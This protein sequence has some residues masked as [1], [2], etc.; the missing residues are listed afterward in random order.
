[1]TNPVVDLADAR[2]KKLIKNRIKAGLAGKRIAFVVW[3]NDPRRESAPARSNPLDA[4]F[5][6]NE[7]EKC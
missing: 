2:R 4:I 7:G 5:D 1:M 6:N 3:A